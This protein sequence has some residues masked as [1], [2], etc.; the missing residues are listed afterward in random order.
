[1][2]TTIAAV[3]TT[4][5]FCLAGCVRDHARDDP[6]QVIVFAAASSTDAMREAGKRFEAQTEIKVAFSFDSSSNLAKQIKAGAPADVFLSADEQ[7][8]NDVA[9]A[10]AILRNTR[11]DLLSNTLV[12]IA[13]V[14]AAFE[15][16]L[17]KV[18]D[19]AT[20]LPGIM[21]IAIG[22]PEFVPAGRY[23]QQALTSLGWWSLLRPRTIPAQDVRAALRLVEIDEADA[24][25][26]YATDVKKLERVVVVAVF[27]P[28]LH[29]PICYPIA[30]CKDSKPAAEFIQFL[31]TAEM[32][33]VFEQ[34]GFRVLSTDE[35]R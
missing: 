26:V 18:F 24:G 3:F 5:L 14:G 31:R 30:Q 19:F 21:R 35:D 2:K 7:W 11:Q 8:M 13:P 16:H 1:M 12:M 29:D 34:A 15:I 23:A 6:G 33:A 32:I 22:D 28:E 10:G 25:I 17:N 20:R 27:P 9:A 4:F